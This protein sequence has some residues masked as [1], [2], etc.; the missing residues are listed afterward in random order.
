MNVARFFEHWGI[1]ENPFRGEEARHDPVFLRLSSPPDNGAPAADGQ[2]RFRPV[3]PATHSEFDKIAGDPARPTTSIVFGEKGSGKTAIRLQLALRLAEHNAQHPDARVLLVPYDD[4]NPV[5]DRFCGRALGERSAAEAGSALEQFRLV[6]HVDAILGLVVPALVDRVLDE[7]GGADSGPDLSAVGPRSVRALG[8]TLRQDLLLLQALY[9][10]AD[11]APSRTLRL[12]RAL[13]LGAGSRRAWWNLLAFGGWALPVGVLVVY[14]LAGGS[15]S[16]IPVLVQTLAGLGLV[17]W[18]VGLAKRLGWD[19]VW[20][21]RLGRRLRRQIRV[22]PRDESSYA[23]SLGQIDPALL[24]PGVLPLTDSD[25]QRYAMLERLR[26]VLRA[27]GCAGMLVVVDRVDEPTLVS[28][29]PEK[30]RWLIWP[31]LNNKFLQQ[32]GLGVKLLLPIELRHALFRESSAFFQEARLDKQNLVERLSWSGP[33]LYDLCNLRLRACLAPDA[34]PVGLA[35][36]FADDVTRE[37]VIDALEQMQQP[38]DAFKLLYQCITLHCSNVTEEQ[39]SW[40][41]PRY[42]LEMVKRE[43]AE[44]V[45]QLQRG[46]RPA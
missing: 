31:L 26:R 42:L 24:E 3:L 16:T 11:R 22:G 29:D 34:K 43:Q 27:L 13:G 9:D 20:T 10:R 40:R 30:M 33:M 4:L 2:P 12:R 38:R 28:G 44:R 19:R 5:V 23:R 37:D 46:V 7:Q 35:D 39:A 21:A 25:E 18:L 15:A 32:Q 45:R 41:I 17:L 36:L 6:D 14:L 8:A 1:V